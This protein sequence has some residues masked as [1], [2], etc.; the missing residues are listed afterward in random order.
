MGI[1]HV[2]EGRKLFTQMS[3]SENLEMGAYV[4]EAWKRREETFDQVYG[5]F[6]VLKERLP[7]WLNQ[8]PVKKIVLAFSTARPYDGGTGAIYILLRKSRIQYQL[9]SGGTF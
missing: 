3:V 9:G 4:H 6:P 1:S 5:V 2:P 8:G 7:I